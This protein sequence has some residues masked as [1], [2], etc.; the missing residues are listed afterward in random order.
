MLMRTSCKRSIPQLL[1]ALEAG[2]VIVKSG[3]ANS[4]KIEQRI[5]E[6]QEKWASLIELANYRKKRLQDALAYQQFS[7]DNDDINQW[8]VETLNHVS[9]EEIGHDEAS[10]LSLVKKHK[11]L[12]EE[13]AH[14]KQNIDAL[15]QQAD[16]LADEVRQFF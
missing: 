4:D 16:A 1:V 15:H 8:M 3:N 11:D 2:E 9:S 5:A 6:V 13:M 12:M 14:Y 7:A 10:A